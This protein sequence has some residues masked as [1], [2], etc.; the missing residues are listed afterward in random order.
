[1]KITVPNIITSVRFAAIP[2]M[3]YTIYASVNVSE[4]YALPAFILFVAIWAT[5]ILDGYIAR[6]F[7]Q[8]SNFGKLFDPFVDKLFQFVTAVMMTVVHKLPIWVPA[9]IFC[10]ELL[11]IIGGTVLLKKYKLVVYSKW[12]GKLATVLFVLA[13][14][15]LFF[16]P[17]ECSSW[18]GYLFILP[19]SISFSAYFK[20]FFDNVVPVVFKKSKRRLNPETLSGSRAIARPEQNADGQAGQDPEDEQED[21]L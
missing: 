14:C 19:L 4:R 7:N 8:I 9:V 13:F 3:A 21:R 11:M 12:Y 15:V 18:S 1:M 10:K 2:V 20:Y 5:D 16:L 6:H 17:A